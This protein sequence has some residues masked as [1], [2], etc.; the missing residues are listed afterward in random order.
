M[1][2]S[3]KRRKKLSSLKDSDIDYSDIAELDASFWKN[4]KLIEPETKKAVSIRLDSD[5][6]DWFKKQGKGYQSLMNSVLKT[7]VQAKRSK[8]IR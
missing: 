2:I 5:I 8:H 6:L 4:A 3:K 7:F 1:S